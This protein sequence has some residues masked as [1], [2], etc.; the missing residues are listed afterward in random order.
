[1]DISSLSHT[2]L[3]VGPEAPT[4]GSLLGRCALLQ[5]HGMPRVSSMTSTLSGDSFRK[6]VRIQI[7]TRIMVQESGIFINVKQSDR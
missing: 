4:N 7:V 6:G 3:G 2:K 5:T 1:M